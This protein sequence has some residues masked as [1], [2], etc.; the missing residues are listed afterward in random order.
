MTTASTT[1]SPVAEP[2]DAVPATPDSLWHNVDFL[3]FWFGETLSLFGSHVTVLALPLTAVIVFNASDEQ[4]GLLRFLQLVP[5]LGLAL[6]LGLWVDRV[7]RRPVMIAANVVRLV[8]IASVPVLYWLDLLNMVTLLVIAC[9][10]GVASVAFDVSWMSYVPALVK[11]PKHYVEAN[12][13]LGTTS[14]AAD[15]AGPGI[16]GL[17]VSAL[18]APVA[19]IVDAF[20]FLASVVSLLLIRTPE[21]PPKPATERRHLLRELRDG[22]VW[23]FGNRILRPLALVAPFCNFSLVTVWTMFLLFAVRDVG[24]NP[25]TVGLV[26]SAASVGGLAGA[27]ASRKLI[28]RFP[29]GL[30]YAVSM[31]A[32]FVSPLLIPLAAGPAPVQVGV[33]IVSFFLSYGGLGV[34]GVVMISLRQT[35]TPPSLMGRMNAAFRTVLFGGGSLGGLFAGILAGA[36]GPRDAI[37]GA[38]I[39]SALVVIGLVISPVSRLK[40][41]PP[42][43]TEADRTGAPPEPTPDEPAPAGTAAA[44]AGAAGSG[45]D[46]AR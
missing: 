6:L 32:I 10:V 16:A 7:R 38:A 39:G 36:F 33:F 17:L 34:A 13:K 43:A 11:D 14:S 18:T 1:D 9:L 44:E 41:M 21:A 20:S 29:I 35:C 23:V 26:L 42:A 28:K 5:Y 8:L 12:S 31:S 45:A 30:V 37:T 46:D 27:A 22:L 15:V 2:E 3:K 24:L 19:M 4:V 25:A 40:E